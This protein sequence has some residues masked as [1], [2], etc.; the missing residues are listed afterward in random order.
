[1]TGLDDEAVE[2]PGAARVERLLQPFWESGRH[3]TIPSIRK[4]KAFVEEQLARFPDIDHYP[5][6]LSDRLKSLRDDLTARM[7]RDDPSWR[8]VLTLPSDLAA[9]LPPATD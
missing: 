1:V 8:E 9:D 7:R 5:H 4:Q 3:D 2:I 6:P